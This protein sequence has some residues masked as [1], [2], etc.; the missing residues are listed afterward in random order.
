MVTLRAALIE[1][2]YACNAREFDEYE[3]VW[4]DTKLEDC[5][6]VE[7]EM[8]NGEMVVKYVKD[9]EVSWILVVRRR[10]RVLGVK[11]VGIVDI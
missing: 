4:G 6:S 2:E 8:R 11:R 10:R 1:G 9:G 7:V 3:D 5:G